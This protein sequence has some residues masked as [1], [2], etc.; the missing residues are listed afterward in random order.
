MSKRSPVPVFAALGDPTRLALVSRLGEG[1]PRSIAQLTEGLD[2]SRQGVT[3]HLRVLERARL[4]TRRRVGRET[5]YAIALGPLADA[6][7][8]LTRASAQ[9]N[10]AIER[11]RAHVEA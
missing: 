4:V 3:K 9:W 8:Y 11:L 1:R 7:A 6:G 5:R 10:R 2:L